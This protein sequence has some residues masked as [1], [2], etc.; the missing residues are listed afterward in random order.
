MRTVRLGRG[1]LVVS[2][3]GIGGIPITRPSEEDAVRVVKR[4]LDLESTSSIRPL[5]T[6]PAKSESG[7]RSP[8][9][10][11]KL[12]SRPRAEPH[13]TS[14]GV[15]SALGRST[16]TCGSFTASTRVRGLKRSS[17]RAGS[18]RMS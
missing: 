18:W 15:C 2:R 3:I 14:S 17:G 8:V 6:A 4:A 9:D 11:A 13:S 5:R 10:A 16:S 7:R 12:S 1:D